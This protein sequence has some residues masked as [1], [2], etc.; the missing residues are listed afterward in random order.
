MSITVREAL[1]LSRL[2][3]VRILTGTPSTR[4][5]SR[6]CVIE[7]EPD[8]AT[9]EG[10][11]LVLV[12]NGAWPAE[13]GTVEAW[14][15]RLHAIGVAAVMI[16]TGC[17]LRR[18]PPA[19]V[20]RADELGLLLLECPWNT[21]LVAVAER[22][23]QAIITRQYHL[24][25]Q[26]E[27]IHQTLTA[28]VLQGKRVEQI[29]QGLAGIVG[30][31]VIIEERDGKIL[32]HAAAGP[33]TPAL[34]P[35]PALLEHLARSHQ[36]RP[37][38]ESTELK[39]SSLSAGDQT[40]DHVIC[41]IRVGREL[42]GFIH[43]LA[44]SK[45]ITDLDLMAA[46][47]GA[48]VLALEIVRQR[49]M[50]LAEER[51][52]TS[53]VDILIHGNF[54]DIGDLRE[55]AWAL[56]FDLQRDYV[57]GIIDFVESAAQMHRRGRDEAFISTG[58]SQVR[59]TAES[60]LGRDIFLARGSDR[61]IFL[62]PA[63]SHEVQEVLGALRALG[64]GLAETLP[65]FPVFIAL[66]NLHPGVGGIRRSY[67]EASQA[68]ELGRLSHFEPGLLVYEEMAVFRLL[69]SHHDPA[70][71]RAFADKVFGP[72]R[73]DCELYRTLRTLASCNFNQKMTSKRLF[74]HINS[75]RYRIAKI[76]RLTGLRLTEVTD[77]LTVDLALKVDQILQVAR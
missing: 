46:Q 12:R 47:H 8:L 3:A 41:P 67:E 14:L 9:L 61:T 7:G 63:G 13:H 66:G 38:L 44:V 25:R 69:S 33:L 49:S 62:H 54:S 10:R 37:W 26:S 39:R 64:A 23:G 21:D 19:V 4:P 76:E 71:L 40:L 35:Q 57:V 51:L 45:P 30:N 77:Q 17:E 32:A 29:C 75:L 59:Q 15:V 53:F 24:L 1:E 65:D 52:R 55:R 22:L 74:L 27:L 68:L 60:Y 18:I 73:G 34:S 42:Y 31:P 58:R 6:T 5:I 48:T 2:P 43:I 16:P 72:L 11:E 28:L 36:S 70:E 56:N 20:R 50:S